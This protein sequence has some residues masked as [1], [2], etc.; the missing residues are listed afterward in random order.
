MSGSG[1]IVDESHSQVST[2]GM[3]LAG[4]GSVE[5]ERL[6]YVRG[7]CHCR[8]RGA[9]Y[10]KRKTDGF[11][12]ETVVKILSKHHYCCVDKDDHDDACSSVDF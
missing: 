6:A 1:A 9:A 2:D 7:H 11:I 4:D 12:V 3:N 5:Y 10:L 8:R